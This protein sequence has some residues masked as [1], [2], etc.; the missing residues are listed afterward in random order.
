M[1]S[2]LRRREG[3]SLAR[4]LTTR[5]S[6]VPPTIVRLRHP[7]VD[8]E[9]QRDEGNAKQSRCQ[10]DQVSNAMGAA[11]TKGWKDRE[12]LK[13]MC[14]RHNPEPANACCQ[15]C[16]GEITARDEKCGGDD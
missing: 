6:R 13:D 5:A 14:Q 1:R 11:P 7:T 16:S 3:T 12:G 4:R 2:G 15:Q 9:A 10:V 8:Q